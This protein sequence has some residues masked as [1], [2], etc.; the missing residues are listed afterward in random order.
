VWIMHGNMSELHDEG[1]NH[2]AKNFLEDREKRLFEREIVNTE[3]KR[4]F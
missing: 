4:V 1:L 3:S 2:K